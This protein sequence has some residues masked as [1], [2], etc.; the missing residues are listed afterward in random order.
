LLASLEHLP[1]QL[2]VTLGEALL[3]KIKDAPTN[4]GY[5][6]SLGRLGARIPFHGP[7]NCVAPPESAESWLKTLLKLPEITLDAASAIVQLGALTEDRERD[8]SGELRE[9]CAAKLSSLGYPSE[10]IESL[11]R[12]VPPAR[13]D[14][15]RIF[16]ES[17]P[18]GLRLV[19]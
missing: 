13:K 17:L 10:L 3:K 1:A 2:R 5:L 19:G 15:Q 7:L 11:R 6:W 4:K 9:K 14:A 16:G 18:E 12:H 8:V